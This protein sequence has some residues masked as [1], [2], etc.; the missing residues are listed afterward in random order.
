MDGHAWPAALVKA[1]QLL[2]GGHT[3]QLGENTSEIEFVSFLYPE[4]RDA[5]EWPQTLAR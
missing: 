3:L 1:P 4:V 5:N 2:V